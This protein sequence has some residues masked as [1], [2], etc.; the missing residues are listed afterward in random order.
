MSTK[1]SENCPTGCILAYTDDCHGQRNPWKCY[2]LEKAA[3]AD[4]KLTP[5]EYEQLIKK[6]TDR[7]S[8]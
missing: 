2:E 6:I 3:L 7:L 5:D 8:L 4:I 1:P